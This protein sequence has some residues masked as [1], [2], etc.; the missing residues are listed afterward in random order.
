[1]KK[2]LPYIFLYILIS[3]VFLNQKSF[4]ENYDSSASILLYHRFGESKFPSTSI[5]IEQLEK[6]IEILSKPEYNVMRLENIASAITRGESLPDKTVAITIDDAF[7]SIY[8]VAW[9]KLR[10]ANLPF[11]V[12]VSTDTIDKKYSSMMNWAQIKELHDSG[13]TIGNHLSTHESMINLESKVWK[14]KIDYAQKR[15]T[16]VLGK[17]PLLFAYPYGEANN[18][19]KNFLRERGYTAAFGQHS[20]VASEWLDPFFLPRFSF[21]EQYGGINRLELAINALALPVKDIIPRTIIIKNN[22]PFL[23]FTVIDESL[24]I[25]KLQC[26]ASRQ[27]KPSV[28]DLLPNNRVEVR[29]A[30]KFKKGRNRVNCTLPSKNNRWHWLGFQLISRNTP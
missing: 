15:L 16:E 22:P 8:T 24:K 29:F 23:G 14:E 25:D 28:I 17:K 6:H 5:S 21:N 18:D 13:V 26:F 12:F 30:E 1:M 9:P 19:M 7:K 20:G 11:T 2:K 10:D 3:F 4:S 27:T